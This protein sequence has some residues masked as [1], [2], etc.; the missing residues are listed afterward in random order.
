[1]SGGL[2]H[3]VDRDQRLITRAALFRCAE[4]E[5]PASEA[6]GR[7]VSRTID[8]LVCLNVIIGCPVASWLRHGPCLQKGTIAKDQK[9][10]VWLL[11]MERVIVY[12]LRRLIRLDEILRS[13]AEIR[14]RTPPRKHVVRFF[15]AIICCG[16]QEEAFFRRVQLVV[17]LSHERELA[18]AA[19]P[20]ADQLA[21]AE[22]VP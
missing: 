3:S 13:I 6:Y 10:T 15:A 17:V 12:R 8:D 16:E 18:F 19:V 14:C 9:D 4:I 2:P 21:G 20:E 5:A 22:F 7:G 11:P 1:M